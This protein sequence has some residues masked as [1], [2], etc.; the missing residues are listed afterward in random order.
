MKNVRSN[1]VY[2]SQASL[3]RDPESDNPNP[4]ASQFVKLLQINTA[5]A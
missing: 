4:T 1:T 3:Y 5:K 2:Y